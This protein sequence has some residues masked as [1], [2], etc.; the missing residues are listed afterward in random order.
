MR[1]IVSAGVL[2]GLADLGLQRA[3][4]VAYGTSAGAVNLAYFLTGRGPEAV[5]I[6]THHVACAR[7]VN[8]LRVRKIIDLEYLFD[9][10]MRK[11]HPLDVEALRE[12]PTDLRVS[13]TDART[14]R[15]KLMSLRDA[16]LDA[17]AV[18]KAS[19]A[20]PFYYGRSVRVGADDYV[21]GLASDALPVEAALADGC[22]HVIVVLSSRMHEGSA[23]PARP[24]RHD[25]AWPERVLLRRHAAGFRRAYLT[26]RRRMRRSLA[27]ALEDPR[28]HLVE[29]G[30]GSPV[31][32]RTCRERLELEAAF[33]AARARG[34]EEFRSVLAP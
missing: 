26:R 24:G 1:A 5:R 28:V 17:Y 31:P 27:L 34:V 11:H 3:F 14:G 32:S 15:N 9:E 22:T 18:L 7:F 25:I 2:V 12:G 16:D 19:S 30:P 13:V 6:Y 33:A 21:D 23:R 20:V 8:P 4:D 29:P 10:V